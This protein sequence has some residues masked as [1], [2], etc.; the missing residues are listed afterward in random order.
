MKIPQN[1]QEERKMNKLYVAM[2]I[3]YSAF[4]IIGAFLGEFLGY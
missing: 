4:R 2:N 3:I 1:T